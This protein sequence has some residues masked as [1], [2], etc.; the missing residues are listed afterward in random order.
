MFFRENGSSVDLVNLYLNQGLFIC[1]N[2]PSMA[3]ATPLLRP[4][5][6]KAGFMT[7]AV[8]NGGHNLR[9][10]FWI[11]LDPPH[12][13]MPSIWKDPRIQKF[14]PMCN[15]EQRVFE[16]RMVKQQPN[17][18][19]FRRNSHFVSESFLTE[20][21]INW[22]NSAEHGGGRSVML[23]ALR[24]AHLL[25]FRRVYL[26]GCDFHMAQDSK[27]F[28][29]EDR[30]DHA[31]T[32]NQNTYKILKGILAELAP[33]FDHVGMQVFNCTAGS[34]LEAFPY[35]PL[36][37]AVALETSQIDLSATTLGMYKGLAGETKPVP[38]DGLSRRKKKR[39][40]RRKLDR[41]RNRSARPS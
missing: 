8:N 25:G 37:D 15:F 20:E 3:K 6:R 30:T 21:T 2:G 19:G 1:L 7:M 16:D 40:H 23:V 28:F 22:G 24:L 9:P 13:F 31:I 34:R 33:I 27:Y 39:L 5:L 41:K 4:D 11:S 12:R 10:D 18:L 32:N 14:V 36:K 35:C 17:V 26:V 38:K 29:P